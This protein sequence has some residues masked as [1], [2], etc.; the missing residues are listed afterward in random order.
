VAQE[1]QQFLRF[2]V[3]ALSESESSRRAFENQLVIR[4]SE[5]RYD[6]IPSYDLIPDLVEMQ[7][8][9]V[10]SLL[11]ASGVQAILI[12][13]PLELPE[14]T[15]LSAQQL[16]MNPGEFTSV[17]QFINAYRGDSFDIRTIVQI[18]GFLLERDQSRLFWHGVIW[19]EDT[20][21]KEQNRIDKIVDLVQFNLDNSRSALRAQ[22]GLPPS[23]AN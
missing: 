22:L 15:A 23:L 17:S 21:E 9:Q 3:M 16:Q 10:R 11:L 5:N 12:L 20:V 2:S 19:L 8:T 6:V 7:T 4:L 13:R 18:A 14:G 1:Q